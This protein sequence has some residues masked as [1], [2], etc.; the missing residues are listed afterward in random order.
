MKCDVDLLLCYEAHYFKYKNNFLHKFCMH[1]F[2]PYNK[3]R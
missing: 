2:A 1:Y 3:K